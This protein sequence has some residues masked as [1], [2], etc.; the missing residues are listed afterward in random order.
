[1]PDEFRQERLRDAGRGKEPMK[2]YKCPDCGKV[3]GLLEAA[4]LTVLLD[5]RPRMVVGCPDCGVPFRGADLVKP[6][7]DADNRC[8]QCKRI[9][10]GLKPGDLHDHTEQC[11]DCGRER[12]TPR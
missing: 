2:K 3:V 5:G 9:V 11:P 1:M 10:V 8:V 12:E 6:P 4:A 7:L